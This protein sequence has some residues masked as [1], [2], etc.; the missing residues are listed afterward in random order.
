MK[1]PLMYVKWINGLMDGQRISTLANCCFH[2]LQVKL[3]QLGAKKNMCLSVHVKDGK[4]TITKQ[5]ESGGG[6]TFQHNQGK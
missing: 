2:H 5:G 6:Q 3:E 4:L 1:S